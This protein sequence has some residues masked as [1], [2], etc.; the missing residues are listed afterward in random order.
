[1]VEGLASATETAM[2]DGMMMVAWAAETEAL[3][4]LLSSCLV[5]EGEQRRTMRMG[6]R[7]CGWPLIGGLV[8]PS[9]WRVVWV[10]H[11]RCRQSEEGMARVRLLC[12]VVALA[13]AWEHGCEVM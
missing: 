6:S 7:D 11:G 3:A 10:V 13:A 8:M 9:V 1:M 5:E 2:G 12:D 4:P